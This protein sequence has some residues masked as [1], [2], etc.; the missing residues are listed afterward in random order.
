[1]AFADIGLDW[2]LLQGIRPHS[3]LNGS[4]SP[5]SGV[6]LGVA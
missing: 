2:I 4:S 1:M 5:Q 3:I 6:T